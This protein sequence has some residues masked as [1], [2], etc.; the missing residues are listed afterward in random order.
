M[1]LSPQSGLTAW[2]KDDHVLGLSLSA[3]GLLDWVQSQDSYRSAQEA[4]DHERSIPV[5]AEPKDSAKDLTD[6]TGYED[7]EGLIPAEDKD[8]KGDWIHVV[9][10]ENDCAASNDPEKVCRRATNLQRP[11]CAEGWTRWRARDGFIQLY[12]Q[13]AL[14]QGCQ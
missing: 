7:D 1:I 12:P 5:R 14:P 6:C 4:A 11:A 8:S 2:V 9:C 10:L 13:D 3:H